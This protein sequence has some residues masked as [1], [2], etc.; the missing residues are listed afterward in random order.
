MQNETA[1]TLR[2][3]D[4]VKPLREGI[5]AWRRLT[6]EERQAWYDRFHEDCRAGR[7]VPYDSAGESRLA[8]LDKG[9]TLT[10]DTVLTVVRARVA[11]PDGYSTRP[12]CCQVFNPLTGETL[13]VHRRALKNTW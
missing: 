2:K 12:G 7:D 11:A 6:D 1:P 13:Y 5:Y 3:G 8:P 10:G 9:V 4:L